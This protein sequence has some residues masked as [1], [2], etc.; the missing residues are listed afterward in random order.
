MASPC[1]GLASSS[2]LFFIAVFGAGSRV[3]VYLFIHHQTPIILD[4]RL[5]RMQ[6]KHSDKVIA[7]FSLSANRSAN[8]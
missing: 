1:Y 4:G 2:P 3:N 5:L 6:W 8:P 7:V